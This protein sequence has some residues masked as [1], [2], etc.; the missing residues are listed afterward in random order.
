MPRG[1]VI[2]RIVVHFLLT[3]CFLVVPSLLGR[4][5]N[6]QSFLSTKAEL[7][8]MA[9]VMAEV[10]WLRWLLEDFGVFAAAPTPLLSEQLR[11]TR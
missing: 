2:L 1:R 6:R 11:V 5:R 3:V 9:F 7:R 10:T 4:Q 8:A